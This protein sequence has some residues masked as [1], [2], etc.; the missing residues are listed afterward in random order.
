MIGNDDSG[1]DLIRK[2]DSPHQV[3]LMTYTGIKTTKKLIEEGSGQ[4][5]DLNLEDE[6]IMSVL[7]ND[8]SSREKRA[9][10]ILTE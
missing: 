4:D 9:Q 5:E 2:E 8:N 10:T 7:C 6:P 1:E 3:P